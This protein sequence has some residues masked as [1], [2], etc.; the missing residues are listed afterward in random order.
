MFCKDGCLWRLGPGYTDSSMMSWSQKPTALDQLLLS[1]LPFPEESVLGSNFPSPA[2]IVSERAE[3][4]VVKLPTHKS[5][6]SVRSF[7]VIMVYEGLHDPCSH[8]KFHFLFPFSSRVLT[9]YEGPHWPRPAS[10]GGGLLWPMFVPTFSRGLSIQSGLQYS[11][12]GQP[13]HACSCQTV[14]STQLCG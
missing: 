10:Q 7:Y 4:E 11:Q 3:V 1:I 5:S 13:S 12:I 2:N 9:A 8:R 6:A 14:T